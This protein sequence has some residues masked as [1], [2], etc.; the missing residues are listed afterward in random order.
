MTELPPAVARYIADADPFVRGTD[1]AVDAAKKFD[2][3]ASKAALSA[4]RMGLAAKEAGE[5]AAVAGRV[6]AEAAEKAAKGFMKEDEAAKLAA[7]AVKELERAEL[8]EAA[9]AIA[10]A[11]ASEK[12][13]KA[14]RKQAADGAQATKSAALMRN[15]LAVLAAAGAAIAPAFIVAGAGAAAFGATAFPTIKKVVE[16][17]EKMAENWSSLSRQQKVSSASTRMLVDDYQDL[18]KAVE[19]DVLR[20][21]N[22]ALAE[23]SRI[24]PRLEPLT[25]SMSTALVDLGNQLGNTLTSDRADQ[26]FSFI[27]AEAAP[28]IGA[29]GETFDSATHLAMS[30]TE[31]LAPLA[32]AGLGVVG[33]VAD[34]TAGLS[35]LSPELAQLAVLGI[36]LRGPLTGMA[37][38]LGKVG[39]KYKT[40]M[41]GATGASKAT[42]LLNLATAAGPNLYMAAGVAI[43]YFALRAL[44]AQ[45]STDKLVASLTVAN[46]AA[47]NN[48]IGYQ[49]LAGALQNKLNASLAAST[50]YM[51]Q[52]GKA[53]TGVVSKYPT[54]SAEMQ[55]LGHEQSQL[56]VALAETNTQIT[57]TVQGADAL[58]K[59]YGLT[60]DQAISLADAVGVNLSRG[61]LDNGQIT[62]SVAGKFDRYRQA[63]E[64]ARNPTAVV[65]QAWADAGNK[66]LTLK[67]Q[68]NAV[69]AA[70]DAYFNPALNVL[71]ATNRMTDALAASNKVLKDSKASTLDRSKAL[72]AQ[73]GPIGQWISAQVAAKKSV[74]LNDRAL[75]EQLPSLLRLAQGSRT[76]QA[77]LNGLIASM[78][79]TISRTK[80]ATTIVDRLGNRVRVLPNGKTILIRANTSQATSAIQTLVSTWNGR[81]ITVNVAT[82][83]ANMG[84]FYV[85]P[86]QADGGLIRGPGT[87]TSDSIVARLSDGE[88]VVNARSTARHRGLLEA[89]NADRYAEGGLVGYARGGK[90]TRVG[91]VDVSTAQWRSLGL[92]LGK[93]FMKAMTGSKSEIAS[94]DRRLEKAVAK[95]FAGKRTTLDNKLIAYLDRNSSR[96]EALSVRRDA[97]TKALAAGKQ[98]AT[99]M[100]SNA[101][102]FAGLSSL[103]G[104]TSGAQV[105]QGLQMK[106]SGLTRYAN[107]LK[108]LGKRG[109]S[110]SLLRQVMDMGPEDGLKY[111]QMLLS[112]DSGVFKDINA[113]QAQIDKTSRSLGRSSADM[114]YDAGKMAGK[115]FL[116]GL[117]GEIK[118]LD[119]SMDKLAKHM[120]ASIKKA[121]HIKSPSQLPAIRQAGAMTVAG[122]AAGMSGN[123][124][125]LD[126]A[127]QAMAVR[128]SRT[129]GAPRPVMRASSV[130]LTGRGAVVQ[131][132]IHVHVAGSVWAERDLFQVV[133]RQA[134]QRNRRNTSNGLSLAGR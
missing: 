102:S 2:R 110:K 65:A 74:S 64:M 62:A 41:S 5:R 81:T 19:P 37:E 39:T 30:L 132:I 58:G 127:S 26:F 105:R 131:Q 77:A 111:G 17:Q 115:G 129:A 114:L 69:S 112:A 32:G 7:R 9:A 104:P 91:G 133:Q 68:V 12:I 25:R 34:L 38:G 50:T 47:G 52:H 119:K 45:T 130:P 13:A 59:K 44:S 107:V 43:G 90:V 23:A 4:R 18:A 56:R 42:K 57:N 99:E 36:G 51:A 20:V 54:A 60:R 124:G 24:M 67:D 27:E 53:I 1:K 86:P 97:A 117:E 49:A 118:S 66:A 95:L 116:T 76:G 21:Y 108:A 113:V 6:A 11:E 71:S 82:S 8:T 122:V 100:T 88:Y 63:V 94:M 85:H 16:S 84:K 80:S 125:V 33:M 123:L 98:Y 22:N 87:G 35:D 78:G 121:L 89:I 28:A 79:G 14:H 106:L 93:D 29:L 126:T 101:R 103:D 48:V 92:Q 46:R 40:A 15:E 70:L 120:A 31:S 3:D 75:R 83:G 73:L 10:A 96:L 61:I 72:E 128:L 134:L 109:L 55:R